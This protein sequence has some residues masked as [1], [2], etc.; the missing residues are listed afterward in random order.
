MKGIQGHAGDLGKGNGR[1]KIETRREETFVIVSVLGRLDEAGAPALETALSDAA[2]SSGGHVVLDCRELVYVN[3]SGLRAVLIGAKGC[4]QEG[5]RLALA[6]LQPN[7]RAVMEMSGLL[8]ILGHHE[9]VEEASSAGAFDRWRPEGQADMEVDERHEAHAVVLSLNGRLDSHGARVL[10]TRI[11]AVIENGTVGMVLDCTR[12]TYISSAGLR[13]L[14]IGAKAC[15]Q[16]GGKLV[17]AGLSPQCRSVVEMS[18]F[19]S[20]IDYR[21]TRKAAIAALV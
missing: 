6:S 9:S 14:L 19:L 11:S 13:S 8:T 21:A 5:G 16:Q 2:R 3:S 15:R 12:M 18:G 4:V 1:M 7:C 10:T 20:V 17:V